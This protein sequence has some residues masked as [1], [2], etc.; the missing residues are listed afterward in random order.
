MICETGVLSPFG[1]L[2]IV[3]NNQETSCHPCGSNQ[4]PLP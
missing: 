2:G 3:D 4:L 1:S